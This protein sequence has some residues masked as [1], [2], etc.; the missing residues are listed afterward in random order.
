VLGQTV[1]N[2]KSG[3]SIGHGICGGGGIV[4]RILYLFL[5]KVFRLVSV[6][7]FAVLLVAAFV[8]LPLF[9]R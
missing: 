3:R 6:A 2:V 9:N 4:N 5:L 7:L 1:I 8:L